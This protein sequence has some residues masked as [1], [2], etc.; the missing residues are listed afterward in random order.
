MFM[1]FIYLTM[2][3]ISLIPSH[4]IVAMHSSMDSMDSRIYSLDL[5]ILLV[6]FF[7]LH[8]GRVF[9]LGIVCCNE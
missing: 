4:Y 8:F 1:H 7:V 3:V 2:Y 5:L 6:I 9:K